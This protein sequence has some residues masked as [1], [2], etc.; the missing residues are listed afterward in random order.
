MDDLK[1]INFGQLGPNDLVGL[2]LL[3]VKA[4]FIYGLNS[5]LGRSEAEAK[6]VPDLQYTAEEV[7]KQIGATTVVVS[8]S[9]IGER[10]LVCGRP[11]RD[12][13]NIAIA[14]LNLYRI[15]KNK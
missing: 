9:K 6:T 7:A 11:P 15:A 10:T 14:N 1:I 3:A 12:I 2:E 8:L 4:L 5:G 13:E